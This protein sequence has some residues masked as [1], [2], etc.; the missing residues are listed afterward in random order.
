M[1]IAVRLSMSTTVCKVDLM[2]Q[3]KLE[4]VINGVIMGALSNCKIKNKTVN[5]RHNPQGA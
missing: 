1:E 2:S 4:K 5:Y 3:I